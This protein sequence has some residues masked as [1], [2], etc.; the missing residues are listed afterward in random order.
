MIFYCAVRFDISE[1]AQYAGRD[2]ACFFEADEI[3]PGGDRET[4]E[5]F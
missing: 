4:K 2:D 3:E 1:L 5:Y